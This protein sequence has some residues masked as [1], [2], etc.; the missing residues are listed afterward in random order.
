MVDR[1][2]QADGGGGC[3]RDCTPPTLGVD[4]N[5]NRIVTDGFSYNN[6]SVDVELY[7]TPYPLITVK[8][9]EENIARLKIYENQGIDNIEHIALAFGLGA[10]ETFSS[11]KATISID[12]SF[13]GKEKLDIFDPENVLENVHYTTETGPCSQ[14]ISA[15][16]KIFNIYHTFRAPL[17]FNMVSTDVWDYRRNGW[18]NYYNHGIE[19]VGKSLNP[20][21]QF[22]G[23]DNGRLV[24]IVAVNKTVGLDNT[25]N[26]WKFDKT[27]YK[28]F[29]PTGKIIKNISSQGYDRNHALF[30]LFMKGQELLAQEKIKEITLGKKISKEP[31]WADVKTIFFEP[32]TRNTDVELQSKIFLEK[33]R[34]EKLFNEL[35]A[36][37]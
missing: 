24:T 25:G 27:W 5:N 19:I 18:Q 10:G 16:C 14:K 2:P 15:D 9:G 32:K 22:L 13:D 12:K 30:P 28:E 11:S 20:P 8:V 6:N 4:S 36:T 35:Y 21:A 33:S 26:V 34:A 3:S 37:R 29:M 1:A 7:Y 31:D 23:I 17:D